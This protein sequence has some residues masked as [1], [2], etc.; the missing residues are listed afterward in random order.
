MKRKLA[1]FLLILS[2]TLNISSISY[3]GKEYIKDTEVIYNTT[4]LEKNDNIK[5][6]S[7]NID[8]DLDT[9][10]K[11]QD[12]KAKYTYNLENISN[13]KESIK[14][15][16]MKTVENIK[17]LD[18]SVLKDNKEIDYSIKVGRVLE[19]TEIRKD[20]QKENTIY[21]FKENY[22]FA[23]KDYLPKNYKLDDEVYIYN[24]SSDEDTEIKLNLNTDDIKYI[25]TN[26]RDTSNNEFTFE[27]ETVIISSQEL[28][29]F[30]VGE[31]NLKD[32]IN[33]I[34]D[35]SEKE[36]NLDFKSKKSNMEEAIKEIS[37]FRNLDSKYISELLD[38]SLKSSDTNIVNFNGFSDE[39]N[40]I[41]FIDFD[42][43]LNPKES[44]VITLQTDIDKRYEQ[45]EN[46]GMKLLF[47]PNPAN[48][49]E[50]NNFSI[51]L[52][53]SKEYNNIEDS[54]IKF[55]NI[56]DRKY[57]FKTDNLKEEEIS[58]IYKNNK[59][60]TINQMIILAIVLVL[61]ILVFIFIM[62]KRKIK[63]INKK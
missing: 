44:A 56:K 60:F 54:N 22:D 48:N 16:L 7:E 33:K 24:L 23:N 59:T 32:G 8:L 12:G 29:D 38:N 50:I 41:V 19:D 1:S 62:K 18:I 5:I 3:A 21:E 42:I 10:E 55:E 26:S 11:G 14:Y 34:K 46:K 36:V 13:K 35:R 30:K 25:I 45:S 6:E 52:N 15:S 37:L 43:E 2:L 27:K 20:T 9:E 47:I 17:D 58:I 31:I 39:L 53:L 61:I 63:S 57:E 49:Q 51:D 40:K 4:I 28:E